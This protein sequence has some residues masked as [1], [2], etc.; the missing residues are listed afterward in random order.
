MDSSLKCHIDS[1][2]LRH[3]RSAL[4]NT[5]NGEHRTQRIQHGRQ[6]RCIG[7]RLR[8]RRS[9][10][11]TKQRPCM[12]SNHRSSSTKSHEDEE[13]S[14]SSPLVPVP[15]K[16]VSPSTSKPSAAASRRAPIRQLTTRAHGCGERVRAKHIDALWALVGCACC[17]L[18]DRANLL[19]LHRRQYSLN[20]ECVLRFV[21][22]RSARATLSEQ[23]ATLTAGCVCAQCCRG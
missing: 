1:N 15:R 10:H 19:H 7:R 17:S 20:F 2:T 11:S 18:Y 8:Q 6:R 4:F 12:N 14:D 5:H 16:S 22:L 21:C 3:T 23:C 13:G 9:E